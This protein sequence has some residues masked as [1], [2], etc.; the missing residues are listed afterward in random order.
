MAQCIEDEAQKTGISG[1][2]FTETSQKMAEYLV[3][4][5]SDSTVRKYY[6][7]FIKWENY[8]KSKG[9]NSVPASPI[10]ISMYLTELIDKKCSYAVVSSTVYGIKW[11][12][13][14]RNLPDP[15]DNNFVKNLIETSKRLYSK[16]V[17]KKEP[18]SAEVLIELC[19]KYATS[20]DIFVIRDL[21][22]IL[23]GYAAFL[24]YDEIRNLRCND[25]SFHEN[26]FSLKINKSK[27]DQYRFGTEV[28]IA[29]G[30]SEACP[31]IMLQRYLRVS[32]Q[33][34]STPKFLFR[35]CIRSKANSFLIYKDKC[36]S[37]TRAKETL[38][39]RLR[40]VAGNL[41]LG[42]HSLRSGGVTAA[43][44]A[45]VNGRCLKRHGRWRA[46]SSKD[47]YVADSLDRRLEVS[48]HLGL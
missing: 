14:L 21:C 27:T 40:E 2:S 39:N 13:S 1:I 48:K 18:V 26:Y 33:S 36:L 6:S 37:Y 17:D 44:N 12:H 47:G 20:D 42:L 19:K 10:L 38:I 41:N 3:N 9:G 45:G 23:I 46:D 16:P 34:I 15:T 11:A 4:S 24:R 8:I 35:P 30:V 32:K 5:K 43:A 31:Y 28:V 22:M 29:K 25:I 7:Y